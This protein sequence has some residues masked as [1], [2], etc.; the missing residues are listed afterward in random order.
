MKPIDYNK[1][2]LRNVLSMIENPILTD[3]LFEIAIFLTEE[4]R[5]DGVFTTKELSS[6]TSVR[7]SSD[8]KTDLSNLI[9]E[10]YISKE[11]RELKVVEHPW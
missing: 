7:I 5:L 4:N 1:V 3:L 10:G 11:G 6:K 9:S 8:L 2:N